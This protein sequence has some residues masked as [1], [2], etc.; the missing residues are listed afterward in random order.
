MAIPKKKYDL[1][2]YYNTYKFK[3]LTRTIELVS[4]NKIDDTPVDYLQTLANK[5]VKYLLTMRGTDVIDWSY[6]STTAHTTQLNSKLFSKYTYDF[7]Q[8]LKR[9]CEYIQ[10]TETPNDDGER[11]AAIKLVRIDYNRDKRPNELYKFIDIT[12]T[13]GRHALVAV[14][15]K[16]N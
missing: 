8:D 4:S 9:C 3:D 16:V 2:L 5:V 12:T 7:V 11:L 14:D 10:R 1:R 6:G 13:F 15:N